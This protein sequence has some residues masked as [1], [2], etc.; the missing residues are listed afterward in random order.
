LRFRFPTVEAGLA[1]AFTVLSNQAP[2]QNFV[3]LDAATNEPVTS[4]SSSSSSTA[5]PDAPEVS[6]SSG[7]RPRKY[8]PASPGDRETRPF[9]SLAVGVMLTTGGIGVELA[10]PVTPKINLRAYAGILSWTTSFT[11]DTIPISGTAHLSNAGFSV[12]WFPTAHNFHISPGLTMY[13]N[14]N[15]NAT[16]FI[17]G[18]QVVTLNDQDYTSDPNDPIHGTAFIQFGHTIAPR[19][20]VGWGNVIRHH[21]ARFTFPVEIGIEYIKP[22]TAVFNLAG[23]SCDSTGDCGPIQDDPDTQKNILEQQNEIISDLRPLRFFPIISFG[24]SYKF[25]H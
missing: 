12:D 13:E 6:Y 20:T 17:P 16:I 5:L 25:G 15:Y 8:A 11:V 1:V 18:N 9:R 23:S 3:K 10:T 21:T 24:I 7:S 2:A 22:P 14:T 19:L 4:A